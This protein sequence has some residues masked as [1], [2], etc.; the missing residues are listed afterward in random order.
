MLGSWTHIANRTPTEKEFEDS[1]GQK[2][3]VLYFGHGSGGQFVR[4]EAVRRLYLNSGTNGEKPG[5][6]TTFLFGYSSVHLSDNSIYEPSGMLASY[7][8]A[9]AP[10]VVGMLWDVT[11]KDCDRCAVKAARS[12]D[13][14]PN[15]SG[16]A[17]EWRRGVGLDEAVKEARKECV[18][19]Y[20]NGAAAVV[21]GIPVYLE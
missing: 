15:E 7:L 20:L 2:D 11:D 21:Y 1:L 17:R 6:A 10:A 13:E 8:T 4:S 19:R 14:S 9:G 5:C 3:L 16:G 18:L 12:A